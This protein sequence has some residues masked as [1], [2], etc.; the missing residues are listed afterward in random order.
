MKRSVFFIY[1][2]ICISFLYAQ[3]STEINTTSE[4]NSAQSSSEASN[5]GDDDFANAEDT[6]SQTDTQKDYLKAIEQQETLVF[7]GTFTASGIGIIGWQDPFSV[8]GYVD[9]FDKSAGF[10]SEAVLIMNAKPDPLLD[11]YGSF[12]VA[13]PLGTYNWVAAIQSVY[14]NYKFLDLMYVKAGKFTQTFGQGRLFTPTNIL[15]GTDA[16]LTFSAAFPTVLKGVTFGVYAQDSYFASKGAIS[17]NDMGISAKAD[18]VLDSVYFSN[19]YFYQTSAGHNG[20][21][22]IK[23]FLFGIDLLAEGSVKYSANIISWNALGGF[24]WENANPKVKVYGEAKYSGNVNGTYTVDSALALG[25][26]NVFTSIWDAG[27]KWY[28]SYTDSSGSITFGISS[29]PFSLLS[30]NIG[31]PVVYGSETGTYV[32]NNPDVSKRKLALAIELK[33]SASF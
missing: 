9:T 13:I 14:C 4:S 2:L 12:S 7:S 26:N 19:G 10:S 30:C 28:H 31:I 16:G 22:S 32:I 15:S 3:T 25:F 21:I 18:F 23:T 29:K 5:L 27:I 11:V 17:Y 8:Q 1:L 6:I 20:A 33:L 24:F